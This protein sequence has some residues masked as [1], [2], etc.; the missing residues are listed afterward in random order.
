VVFLAISAAWFLAHAED[1]RTGPMMP[2][3]QAMAAQY[4]ASRVHFSIGLLALLSLQ[5]DRLI[6]G[7][8]LSLEQTG[9]YFRQ[10]FLAM[11]MYQV[12]TVFS[13]N[14]VLSGVYRNIQS[15]ESGRAKAIL[16]AERWRVFPAGAALAAVLLVLGLSEDSPVSSIESLIPG[17]LSGL[18]LALSFRILADYNAIVLNALHDERDIF[19]SQGLSLSVSAVLN[20][21]LTS[22]YGLYGTVVSVIA[23]AVIYLLTTSLYVR[24]RFGMRKA[25]L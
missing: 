1:L 13:Y 18:V 14:R 12:A 6:V 24:Q 15:G 3:R 22:H 7:S 11:S 21:V 19:R 2:F 17:L 25:D 20:V 9:I 10:V 5:A 4:K 16:R 23:G 8:L